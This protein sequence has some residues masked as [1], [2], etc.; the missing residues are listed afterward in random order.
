M[1]PDQLE[2]AFNVLMDRIDVLDVDLDTAR[3]LNAVLSDWQ[4]WYWG[5]LDAW[6]VNDTARWNGVYSDLEQ[7]VTQLEQTAGQLDEPPVSEPAPSG[8][9]VA[10]PEEHIYGTWPTWMKVAAGTVLALGLY[11]VLRTMK[12]L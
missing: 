1:N 4:D 10:L 2:A 7:R 3:S 12:V 6:P 5:N 11:K 9:I 8:P